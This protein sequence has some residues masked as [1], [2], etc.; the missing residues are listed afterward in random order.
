[1]QK[2][3]A[4][5]KFFILLFGAAKIK[6]RWRKEMTEKVYDLKSVKMPRLAG[7]MLKIF[8]KMLE[9]KTIGKLLLPKLIRDAGIIDFRELKMTEFPTYFPH[10]GN[11][12]GKSSKLDLDSWALAKRPS[13]KGFRFT[14]IRNYADAYS[15]S[16]T[17][18]EKIAGL[19]LAAIEESNAGGS[20]LKAFISCQHDD[21]LAQ[22]RASTKRWKEG[23]P[24]SV[25]DGVPIA[26]KDEVDM[27]P[28]GTTFGT[29][30]LGKT[31]VSED[32]TVVARMRAGGAMLLGKANMNEIGIGITGLNVHHGTPRNPYNPGHFSGGSSSGSGVS[33]AAGLCPAAI[34]ADG[35]GSIRIPA[36][37]CGAVGIKATFGRISDYNSR[38]L[39]WTVAHNGPIAATAEDAALMYAILAGPD[40][41][42]PHTLNQPPVSLDGFDNFNL[43]DLKIGIF[44]PWFEH[45]CP[46]TVAACRSMVGA[47][48]DMGASVTEIEIPDL[49]ANRV[50][51]IITIGTEMHATLSRE[52]AAQRTEFGLD[53]RT[54][55]ALI[56]NFTAFDYIQAQRVRTR[57]IN[58][59]KR[60]F[61]QVDLIL[62]PTTGCPAPPIPAD[63]LAMGESDLTTLTE[64]M[65]FTT[66][67][68]MTGLPAISFPAGYTA[69]GLPIGCQL[70][71]R[72]WDE[73]LLLRL[74]HA[75]EQ[76]V[77]RRKPQVHY[78][79][80]PDL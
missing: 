46:E 61:E 6:T 26:V 5:W 72:A 41:K 38:A 76:V 67:P 47:F 28:Y 19:A 42:D 71:G 66:A 13:G 75:A 17:T 65:R 60:A 48:E 52:Y 29:R 34:S 21:V 55:L 36:S 64:I 2:R 51:L 7:S 80:L 3:K 57:T 56:S 1:M 30:F 8:V 68:N 73:H 32:S 33:V 31:P 37:F 54:N 44:T 35:G 69:S 18:P 10:W 25:F 12:I 77:E 78:S 16:A 45:A 11:Q 79:F 15:S 43:S 14:T 4:A 22:A 20:G 59:F 27:I 58:S 24:L 50:S 40:P 63:A 23:K 9:S 39:C 53:V 49:E 74:A 62:T 70:I